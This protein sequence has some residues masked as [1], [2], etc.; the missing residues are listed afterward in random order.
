MRTDDREAF[1]AHLKESPYSRCVYQCDNDAVDHQAVSMVY[2]DGVTVSWQ[3]SAFTMDI[4]R[5][6]K[7]MGTKGELEGSIDEDQYEIRDF[8]TGNVTTV[9][10][11]TPKTLHS[12]GDECI[13]RNYIQALLNPDQESRRFGAELSLQGHVM[14][15]AAEYSRKNDGEVVVL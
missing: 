1:L 13:M 9:K 3:A 5:Q 14:A 12:G 7:I 11:H 15:Y 2:E 10:I 4:K 6:T 8:A